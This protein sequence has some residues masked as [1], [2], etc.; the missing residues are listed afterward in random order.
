MVGPPHEAPWWALR[1]DIPAALEDALVGALAGWARGF[2]VRPGAGARCGLDVYLRSQQSGE[3]ARSIAWQVLQEAGVD[4]AGCACTLDP[5]EDGRWVERYQA[6]LQPVPIGRRF[7]VHP[8]GRIGVDDGREPL[9]LVPGRAFGTGEHATTQLC[10][11]QLERRVE[12]G[13]S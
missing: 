1:L 11:E 3:R 5:V 6:S 10:V 12:A 8:A 7:T 4:P 9:L 2:E 13:S